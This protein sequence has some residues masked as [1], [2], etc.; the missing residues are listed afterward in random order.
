[1]PFGT[2]KDKNKIKYFDKPSMDHKGPGMDHEG[3]GMDHKG[4]GKMHGPDA[5]DNK[6]QSNKFIGVWSKSSV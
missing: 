3:P 6:P 4:P 5:Y 1:M 2:H